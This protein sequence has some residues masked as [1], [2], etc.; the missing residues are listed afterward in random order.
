MKA[1]Y[2]ILVERAV[3]AMAA[4]IE[5]HNKPSFLYRLET[6]VIL[7][8]NAWELLLKAK[9]LH[10]NDNKM[11]SLYIYEKR[12]NRPRIKRSRSKNPLTH[13][14]DYLAQ[15]LV[16]GKKLDKNAYENLQ[17]LAE[18]RNSAVH[19]YN[20]SETL[21]KELESISAAAVRNFVIA[22][23][24]WF[25][26]DFA[27]Y[28]FCLTP[29]TF[30]PPLR[31]EAVSVS[32]EEQNFLDY[33]QDLK[34]QEPLSSSQYFVSLDIDV[35]FRGSRGKGIPV[36]ITRNS[37]APEVRVSDDLMFD[38]YQWDYRR[39]IAECK[40]RYS[41][42]KVNK[43]VYALKEKLEQKEQYAMVRKLDPNNPKSS[44]QKFYSPNILNELDKVYTR[45]VDGPRKF[46]F[47]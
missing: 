9:W 34:A 2:K 32:Q 3:S 27:K 39:L 11:N 38:Y 7:A 26:V 33:I 36:T 46:E 43:D 47:Y 19:F 23:E 40:K 17:A 45:G 6:F 12:G 8:T 41:D 42:F 16:E 4:A 5:V 14:L 22:A 28:N 29:L 1:R 25:D 37:D 13:S 44:K 21:T 35:Q 10:D 20:E 30:L 18:I 15:R 24:D 31:A